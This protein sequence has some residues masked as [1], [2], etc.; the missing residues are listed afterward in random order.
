MVKEFTAGDIKK[1][2]TRHKPDENDLT[3]GLK[4]ASVLAPFYNA[5][6][7]LSLIFTKRTDHLGQ[8]SGQI[9]FPGGMRDPEDQTP[10]ETALR[11]TW[12]EIGVHPGDVEVWGRLNQEMTVTRFSVAPFV[13][14][15]PYPYTFEINTHEVERLIIVPLSTLLDPNNFSH[16]FFE[17]EGM[18]FKTYQYSYNGD[19]IWGAT[20]RIVNNLLT[21]LTTGKEPD[22]HPLKN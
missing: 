18:S 21:L 13:G 8:H 22:D 17:W 16:D 9:S 5:P 7:G 19:V 1:I 20:A 15:I 2:L 6:G 4:S 11:E 3:P 14:L 12:E 10:E